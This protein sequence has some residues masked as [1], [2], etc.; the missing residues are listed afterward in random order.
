MGWE[1]HSS[2]TGHGDVLYTGML[3]KLG[4]S[5][6]KCIIRESGKGGEGIQRRS[7]SG[8]SDPR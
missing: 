3:P 5:L 2:A 6:N 8:R 1:T 7:C 4:V